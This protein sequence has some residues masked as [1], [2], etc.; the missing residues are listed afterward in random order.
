MPYEQFPSIKIFVSRRMD[1]NSIVVPN[2][3]YIPVRCGAVFDQRS[4]DIQGDDSGENISEKRMSFCELTVQYWAWKNTK[5]DYY[6]LCHYRRYFSFSDKKY[7]TDHHGLVEYPLLSERAIK[8]FGLLNTKL[9]INEISQYDL[10]IPQPMPV[11][12][13]HLP[14][15][16]VKT[17]YQLWKAHEDIFFDRRVIDRMFQLI[18]KLAP[19]YR[20]SAR[21]YFNSEF[22]IGYNCYIMNNS[23]FQRLCQFQFPI[24]EV[25]EQ[26]MEPGRMCRT[27]AYVAEMLFGIFVYHVINREQWRVRQR[28]L[29]FFYET[30]TRTAFEC[31]CLYIVYFSDK[32]VHWLADP[33][34]PLGSKRR[35]YCKKLYY[36]LT[37]MTKNS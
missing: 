12:R 17:V 1:I 22:H 18:D 26:E 19:Y 35:E 25:I 27:P 28:Q 16:K 24:M 31:F 2:P 3:L 8:R 34:F 5:S 10:I 21:E 36:R 32:I 4:N 9:M 11:E 23:L 33:F 37:R 14:H 7:K 20:T 29:V 6:G 30:R 13:M 15:R